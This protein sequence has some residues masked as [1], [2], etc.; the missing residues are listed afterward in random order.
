MA[1]SDWQIARP[2][3]ETHPSGDEKP[4]EDLLD[5]ARPSKNSLAGEAP[6]LYADGRHGFQHRVEGHL[7]KLHRVS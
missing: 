7:L 6:G 3:S 2:I 4:I 1:A 5:Y